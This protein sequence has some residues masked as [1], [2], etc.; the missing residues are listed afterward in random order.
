MEPA[1]WLVGFKSS[2][3]HAAEIISTA[4]FCLQKSF[5]CNVVLI[6]ARIYFC[7]SKYQFYNNYHFCY[8]GAYY[9]N[10]VP[11]IN[12]FLLYITI[13]TTTTI[14]ITSQIGNICNKLILVILLGCGIIGVFMYL[15][16]IFSVGVEYDI[17]L[18]CMVF[19]SLS[20]EV[21]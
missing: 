8:T 14:I 10:S 6:I 9:V 1:Q 15:S 20:H 13:I 7:V 21:T 19:G 12:Q 11:F 3:C 4:T 2:T 16:N 18:I 17:M 5:V